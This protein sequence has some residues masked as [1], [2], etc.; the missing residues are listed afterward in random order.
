MFTCDSSHP[1]NSPADYTYFSSQTCCP[2]TSGNSLLLFTFRR[3]AGQKH[4]FLS[5]KHLLITLEFYNRTD[6]DQVCIHKGKHK[7]TKCADEM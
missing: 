1:I 5:V 4:K 6:F 7:S 3:L 2:T